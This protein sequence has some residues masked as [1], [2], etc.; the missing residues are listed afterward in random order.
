MS[1]VFVHDTNIITLGF[2]YLREVFIMRLTHSQKSII[3]FL[4]GIILMFLNS[5]TRWHN[6]CFAIGAIICGILAINEGEKTEDKAFSKFYDRAGH[7]FNSKDEARDV[8]SKLKQLA[9]YEGAFVGIM[10]IA[11]FLLYKIFVG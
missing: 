11:P 7:E 3:Y 6:I 2:V 10:L 9:C 5:E 4:L 1:L 8:F